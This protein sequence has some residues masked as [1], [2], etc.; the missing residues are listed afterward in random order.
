MCNITALCTF[1]HFA[2]VCFFTLTVAATAFAQ[3]SPGNQ[4]D[5]QQSPAPQPSP[6]PTLEHQFLKNILRD[7]RDIWTAPFSLHQSDAR[8]ILPLTASS[9][10]L[11]ATDRHSAGELDEP[12][13]T[14]DR[15]RI[16]SDISRGG[17]FY[18]TSAVAGT[19]YLIG[20]TRNNYRARETGVLAME[21]LIDSSFVTTVLKTASQRPRPTVDD[22]SGEFF[23]KG[24]SFPSGHASSIWSVATVIASEY[25]QHRPLLRFASYGL[26]AAVSMSRYTGQKHFLSDVLVGSAIG[27]GIGTYV[28]RT[29][30]DPSTDSAD[31]QTKHKRLKSKLIPF[32]YP[33]YSGPE[34]SYG[35]AVSWPQ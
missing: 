6:S 20:R 27:Y 11:F 15:L 10:I 26:A 9:A 23:D 18:T 2:V 32:A 35:L 21:A 24:S 34:R 25:G 7:Q 22:A 12:G 3:D 1:R 8:W 33:I 31:H 4:P 5:P 17:S 16:S 28:Y 13:D 29:H 30:H 19:F 14:R